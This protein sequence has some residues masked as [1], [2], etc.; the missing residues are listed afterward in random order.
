MFFF[1]SLA[2]TDI[3]ARYIH[4]FQARFPSFQSSTFNGH[5]E[6]PSDATALSGYNVWRAMVKGLPGENKPDCRVSLVG[7]NNVDVIG[8]AVLK[9][10]GTPAFGGPDDPEVHG[11]GT[12]A[13]VE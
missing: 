12:R 2:M 6:G 5:W 13:R 11:H 4:S 9:I 7:H 3:Q 10:H 8:D 1:L